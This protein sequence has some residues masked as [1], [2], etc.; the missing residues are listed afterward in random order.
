MRETK[1]AEW[2][3]QTIEQLFFQNGLGIAPL[4]P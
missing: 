1:E 3:G 2:G 4:P